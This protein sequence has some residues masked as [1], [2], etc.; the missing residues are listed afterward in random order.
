MNINAQL[1]RRL[2]AGI[3]IVA[4]ALAVLFYLSFRPGGY[5]AATELAHAV[6]LLADL[7]TIEIV[8]EGDIKKRISECSRKNTPTI[9]WSMN[10][11]YKGSSRFLTGTTISLFSIITPRS[12]TAVISRPT[13]GITINMF[14][15]FVKREAPLRRPSTSSGRTMMSIGY[16]SLLCSI[17]ALY[18]MLY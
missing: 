2:V 5:L 9:C 12:F 16:N 3:P 7:N 14:L 15:R 10:M 17:K 6:S 18:I 8:T 13:P 4:I 11:E 1:K